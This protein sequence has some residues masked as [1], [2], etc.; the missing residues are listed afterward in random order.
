L[1][2]YT[3]FGVTNVSATDAVVVVKRLDPITGAE[4]PI[5][6]HTLKPNQSVVQRVDLGTLELASLKVEVTGGNVWAFASIV[7]KG[8]FDPEYVAATPLQ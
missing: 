7:D 1:K 8:T 3:N 5:Q 4:T 2:Y 6:Q